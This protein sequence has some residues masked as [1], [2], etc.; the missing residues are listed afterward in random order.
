MKKR[1]FTILIFILILSGLSLLM[2][3]AL[4]DYFNSVSRARDITTYVTS[5]AEM[6]SARYEAVWN[7]A[8]AYNERLAKKPAHWQL[9]EQETADYESQLDIAGRG[10][11]AY[12][13]IP[14]LGCSLPVYHGTSVDVLQVAI[15]HLEGTSL[16]VGGKSSHC[17]LSGHRG[18]PSAKLFSNLDQLTEGDTFSVRT[19]D[20]TLSYEVDEIS[21]VLPE[22]TAKL[23]IVPGKDLCG[24][25]ADRSDDGRPG[26]RHPDGD[27]FVYYCD[28]I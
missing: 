7:D 1:I 3:P 24:R 11:M 22:E 15:G 4:S 25:T 9:T 6:D 19:L 18:L 14:K 16:P 13:E 8:V 26:H 27:R 28:N 2:F 5:V 23:Q 12:I 21:I 10:I 20:K 17:V